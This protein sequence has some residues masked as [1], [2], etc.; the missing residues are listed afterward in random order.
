MARLVLDSRES[1]VIA[2][3]EDRNVFGKA[4]SAETVEVRAGA[5]ATFGSDFNSNADTILVDG[6][7]S[8][9]SVSRSGGTASVADGSTNII[10]P[11]GRQPTSIQFDDTTIELVVDSSND[12]VF[13]SQTVTTSSQSVATPGNRDGHGGLSGTAD[14][15]PTGPSLTTF[16]AI[17]FDN[18]P[19][20][21]TPPNSANSVDIGRNETPGTLQVLKGAQLEVSGQNSNITVS[22][23]NSLE[24]ADRAMA[25]TLQE[26]ALEVLGGSQVTI[27]SSQGFGGLTV[28]NGGN[29]NGRALISGRQTNFTLTGENASLQVGQFGEGRLTVSA[30]ARLVAG[31]QFH[32]IGNAAGSTGHLVVSGDGSRFSTPGNVSIASGFFDDQGDDDPSNDFGIAGA[33]TTGTLTVSNQADFSAG[34]LDFGGSHN[35]S[36]SALVSS[37]GTLEVDGFTLANE[38]SGELKI[39]DGGRFRSTGS[40]DIVANAANA[41]GTISITGSGSEL[42]VQ[43]TLELR[44][45]DISTSEAEATGT[46]LV[47]DQGRVDL[48]QLEIGSKSFNE[49]RVVVED[50][51]T[52]STDRLVVGFDPNSTGR[53]VVGSDGNISTNELEIGQ[54]GSG[55][56]II[57]EGGIF[58]STDNFS[59]VAN[60][61]GSSGDIL[62]TGPGSQL[63]LLGRLVVGNGF[64][65]DQGNDDPGDDF[66]RAGA[67]TTGSMTV[68]EGARVNTFGDATGIL[69]GRDQL[70]EGS[71]AALTV[72]SGASLD[73]P[74][75]NAAGP[76]SSI[77]ITDI[78]TEVTVSSTFGLPF[79]DFGREGG[80]L[81]AA[82]ND[83]EHG[84][85][86]VLNGARVSVTSED[87]ATG[88]GIQIARNPGSVGSFVAD[89]Q[90]TVVEV[91]QSGPI[92]EPEGFGPFLTLGRDGE[93]TSEIRNGASVS[94][95]GAQAIATVSRGNSVDF[96]DPADAPILAQSALGVRSGATL[97]VEGTV[98]QPATMFIGENEN[99]NGR[100]EVDGDGS[101][102]EIGAANGGRF[103][104][105]A[106]FDFSDQRAQLEDGGTG[107]VTV[108]NGGHLVSGSAVG[109][110]VSDIFVGDGGTLHVL[111]DGLL[112]G[113]VEASVNGSFT[114]EDGGTASGDLVLRGTDT[115]DDF[116]VDE[117]VD[118][119][120]AFTPGSDVIDLSRFALTG[121][122]SAI[123]SVSFAGPAEG[124]DFQNAVAF[125]SDGS[126]G[127]LFID[128]NN[129]GAYESSEDVAVDVIGVTTV[130]D[131][132]DFVFS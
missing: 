78:G 69:I 76:D 121:D 73:T 60:A 125:G 19:I 115:G 71:T 83:G 109:D 24:F 17:F 25:P 56:L 100:L 14:T 43:D 130:P 9:Y 30:G 86:K 23:G 44:F 89:G 97:F 132:G 22:P 104:V 8:S 2:A 36:A 5:S 81:R 50:S 126:D 92:L 127:R 52:L 16:G 110:G 91:V 96:D 29:G 37:G 120:R 102:V 34:F 94:L 107:L 105:G 63:E 98:E 62:V 39:Q 47:S 84:E 28:G 18:D 54:Q 103:L 6:Q 4:G 55:N 85:I 66:G 114:V 74:W 123:A 67:V 118:G 108:G 41:S 75:L 61:A 27:D 112:T 21:L 124:D 99:G 119:L 26:S 79:P 45:A 38:G 33:P 10:L 80:F 20:F 93:G 82:R 128:A 90:D 77:T 11:A 59:P 48:D 87:E 88:P 70:V 35:S 101:V 58:R 32:T 129:S 51:G 42:Q 111:N 31:D 40:F 49:G 53:V 57:S 72:S 15:V 46:L 68:E 131:I 113:D 95:S 106:N 1:V 12:V 13:G 7:S 65:D 122:T 64:F 117:S 3:G 116:R